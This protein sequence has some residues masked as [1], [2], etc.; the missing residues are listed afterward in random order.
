VG[1]LGLG[2]GGR[3]GGADGAWL[4]A[5]HARVALFSLPPTLR[6]DVPSCPDSPYAQVRGSMAT[7]GDALGL[8]QAR[9]PGGQHRVTADMR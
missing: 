6:R 7:Q 4:Q 1:M 9:L 5:T 3:A 8:M 2:R